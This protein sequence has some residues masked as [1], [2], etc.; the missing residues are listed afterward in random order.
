MG[1]IQQK[2]FLGVSNKTL[3]N[4]FASGILHIAIPVAYISTTRVC[5]LQNQRCK[6]CLSRTISWSTPDVGSMKLMT[7]V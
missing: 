7:V 3:T 5:I 1:A 6:I 2:K 4:L